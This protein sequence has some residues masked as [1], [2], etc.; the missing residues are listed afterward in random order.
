MSQ[1]TFKFGKYKIILIDVPEE[2]E[3]LLKNEIKNTI[4]SW[5][6]VRE[7]PIDY[8]RIQ[9]NTKQATRQYKRLYVT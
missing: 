5:E 3:S 2:L 9:K 6:A 4:R 1:K 7:V 8:K